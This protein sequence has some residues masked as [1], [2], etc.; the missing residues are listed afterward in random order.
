MDTNKLRAFADVFELGSFAAAGLKRGVDPSLLSRAVSSLEEELGSKL[1]QRTTRKLS[2]TSAGELFY[3][4]IESILASLDD[5]VESVRE[6][7]DTPRGLVRLSLPVAFGQI[8][9]IPALAELRRRYP[10]LRLDIS[11]TNRI[12]DIVDEN[13]DVAV[14][15][16][17]LGDSSAHAVHLCDLPGALCA[18]PA[19]LRQYGRP[20]A[21]E[22]IERHDCL[23]M[24]G[25]ATHNTW[26]FRRR[27][28]SEH[29]IV[30][31]GSMRFDSGVAVVRAATEGLG[32]ALMPKRFLFDELSDGRLIDLFPDYDVAAGDFDGGA[33]AV[34]SA[35]QLLPARIRAVLNFLKE[36]PGGGQIAQNGPAPVLP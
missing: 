20:T 36:L 19:Y 3:S 12:V 21:P 30:V 13:I 9:V 5:A 28:G 29:R 8:C 35:R 4:Q 1:F 26:R 27:D 22:E 10:G 16:G 18:S 11:L 23:R 7:Q 24:L 14:R 2:P 15:I 17:N 34:F 33:W 25:G 31:T 6:Q 32:L